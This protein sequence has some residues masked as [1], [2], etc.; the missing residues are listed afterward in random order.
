MWRFTVWLML[1]ITWWLPPYKKGSFLSTVDIWIDR[2]LY[3]KT[4]S[5][6]LQKLVKMTF[7]GPTGSEYTVVPSDTFPALASGLSGFPPLLYYF[8]NVR[9]KP[10][11]FPKHFRHHFNP[12]ALHCFILLLW[13]SCLFVYCFFSYLH[14]NGIFLLCKPHC[15]L[16]F[17]GQY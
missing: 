10:V 14:F 1:Q 6:F 5:L 12:T 17:E 11:Y 8:F 9:Q 2:I 15:E 13:F 7:I 16:W 4:V 3:G